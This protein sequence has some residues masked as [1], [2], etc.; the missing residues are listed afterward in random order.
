MDDTKLKLAIDNPEMF[1]WNVLLEEDDESNRIIYSDSFIFLSVLL[2]L[3]SNQNEDSQL[4]NTFIKRR[5]YQIEKEAHAIKK[6]TNEAA[7]RFLYLCE[8]YPVIRDIIYHEEKTALS[9]CI[10]EK[11]YKNYINI[12]GDSSREFVLFAE[13][14]IAQLRDQSDCIFDAIPEIISSYPN[15][16]L[17]DIAKFKSLCETINGVFICFRNDITKHQKEAVVS[18]INNSIYDKATM[19][20]IVISPLSKLQF[21]KLRDLNGELLQSVVSNMDETVYLTKND[22]ENILSLLCNL[23]GLI[24]VLPDEKHM[25]D[26]VL[27]SQLNKQIWIDKYDGTDS[28]IKTYYTLQ[29]I[30]KTAK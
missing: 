3:V 25:H 18:I 14:K 20:Y 1:Y 12:Y 16:D 11:D 19:S 27:F 21:I 23:T 2:F 28:A 24:W 26:N 8:K 29:P 7:K 22:A 5:N 13:Y 4:V 30:I 10:T 9:E 15:S 6:A 17:F